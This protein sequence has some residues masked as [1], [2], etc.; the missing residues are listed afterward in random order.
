VRYWALVSQEK[1]LREPTRGGNMR[2]KA[3]AAALATLVIGVFAGP[4]WAQSNGG[5]NSGDAPGQ[6]KAE[7]NCR[8][9]WSELQA[10]LVAG[11]GPKSEPVESIGST[12]GPTNCDHFWQSE[13]VIGNS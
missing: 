10:D 7:A 8:H 4:A 11:G 6:A 13:G 5:G 3:C 1:L 9:V 2:R 12:S